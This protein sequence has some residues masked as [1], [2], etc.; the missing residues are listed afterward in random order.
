MRYVFI[1]H[2]TKDKPIALSIYDA[3][4]KERIPSFIDS[5]NLLIDQP[6][7]YGIRTEIEKSSHMIVLITENSLQSKWVTREIATAYFLGLKVLFIAPVGLDLR[8]VPSHIREMPLLPWDN[9]QVS[10]DR[11]YLSIAN[12]SE[13]CDLMNDAIVFSKH[14][15]FRKAKQLFSFSHTKS[16]SVNEKC[17][18]AFRM[19]Q[20][21]FELRELKNAHESLRNVTNRKNVLERDGGVALSWEKEKIRN[22]SWH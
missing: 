17:A 2:S 5:N 1:S 13:F 18:A 20:C 9:S 22:S 21:D 4:N 7:I 6:L 12:Q 19:A 14:G 10:L 15:E 3:L 8:L 11:L 16:T